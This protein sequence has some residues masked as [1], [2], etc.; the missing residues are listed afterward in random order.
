MDM[1]SNNRVLMGYCM[2]GRVLQ[3]LKIV[4]PFISLKCDKSLSTIQQCTA[5]YSYSYYS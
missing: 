2:F 4:L 3:Y 1:N 5:A